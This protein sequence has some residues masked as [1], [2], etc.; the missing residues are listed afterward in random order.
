MENLTV[1]SKEVIPVY[2]TEHGEKVVIGR[3][4]HQRLN[5]S[6]KYADWFKNICGYGFKE[7]VDYS[8]FSRNL[9]IG[10]RCK[11]HILTLDMA[12]HIAMIQ[13][14]SQGMA[15]RQKLIDLEK[16]RGAL[17]PLPSD[18]PTALR[19]YADEVERNRD[20]WNEN[21]QQRLVIEAQKEKVC[22]ADAVAKSSD[23]IYVADLAKLI[24]QNGV[25]TGPRRLFEKLRADGY[26][27]KRGN[28]ENIPTERSM[29]QGLF[30]IKQSI[31][32][33]TGKLH[34]TPMV[35]AKGQIYFIKRYC[36]EGTVDKVEEVQK[37]NE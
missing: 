31:D 1:F 20:L 34:K 13:R 16:D 14:S 9:E 21:R 29:K 27:V 37:K 26:L 25:N 2:E 24:E 6:S 28:G 32:K 7:N 23:C 11:E 19:A 15:I 22:F 3:E 33:V 5:I 17:I 35:T 4:L 10:G 36:S 12:K 30:R 8:T 18:F